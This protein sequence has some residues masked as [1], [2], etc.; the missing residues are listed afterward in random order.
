VAV[1]C[2]PCPS[3]EGRC[4]EQ[5][6]CSP[7]SPHTGGPNACWSRAGP[8]V[9]PCPIFVSSSMRLLF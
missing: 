6:T 2:G 4:T 8:S 1:A 9:A 3:G 7:A 5:A